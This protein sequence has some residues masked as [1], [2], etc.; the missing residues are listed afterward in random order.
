MDIV[1][2]NCAMLSNSEVLTLLRDV[3]QKQQENKRLKTLVSKGDY[4]NL[5]TIAYETVKF[6]EDTPANRQSEQN[7]REFML[8]LK[9]LNFPLTKAEKLQ[10]L[11]HRPTT[12]VELQLLIEECEERFSEEAL[13]QLIEIINK[14]LP[15]TV[16]EVEEEAVE[17][18]EE[19]EE[20]DEEEDEDENNED[21]DKEETMEDAN[22]E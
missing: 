5:A 4:K 10:I 12:L 2:N 21:T 1:N 3:Q 13:Q 17:E 16:E 11:N 8:K 14:T 6:L 19:E 22:T 20:E 7:V 15:A 18:D 9:E